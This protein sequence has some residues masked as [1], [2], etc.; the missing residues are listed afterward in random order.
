MKYKKMDTPGIRSP[1]KKKETTA[2]D[3]LMVRVT[4]EFPVLKSN[5]GGETIG[6]H[7]ECAAGDLL[8]PDKE[9]PHQVGQWIKVETSDVTLKELQSY[10]KLTGQCYL[11]DATSEDDIDI[12]EMKK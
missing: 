9:N 4:V 11:Y 8:Y 10:S 7:L 6:T 12:N 1:Y 3:V 2:K 5:Y